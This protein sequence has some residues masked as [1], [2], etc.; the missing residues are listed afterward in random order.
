MQSSLRELP[1]IGAIARQCGVGT[2]QVEYV[3]LSR[4]IKPNAKAGRVLVYSPE[5]VQEISDEL[6][7]IGSARKAS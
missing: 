4:G 1:T 2:H 7:K 6:Q 5:A 3:I